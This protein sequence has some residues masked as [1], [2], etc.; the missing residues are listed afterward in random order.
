MVVSI[1]LE[2]KTFPVGKALLMYTLYGPVRDDLNKFL[3][4]LAV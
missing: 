1:A 3:F 4:E 2:N